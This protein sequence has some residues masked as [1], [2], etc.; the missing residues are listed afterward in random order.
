MIGS[1]VCGVDG[2]RDSRLALRTATLLARR[3]GERLVVVHV[4]QRPVSGHTLGPAG[5][6][7]APITSESVLLASGQALIDKILEEEEIIGADGNAIL[8]FPVE[9]RVVLGFPAE[10]LADAADDEQ[11]ELI[12]V[13]SRGRGAF[14]AALL[15]SVSTDLIGIA[16]CPV[17]VVPPGAAAAAAAAAVAVAVGDRSYAAGAHS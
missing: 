3:L 5:G 8:G 7:P 4:V 14:K 6:H 9:T 17:L 2:S 16:R 15:G 13:G 1:V 10:G 11:A 12:V